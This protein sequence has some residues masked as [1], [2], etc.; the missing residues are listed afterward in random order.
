[1][2]YLFAF[3][4]TCLK[5]TLV[6]VDKA[7][8]IW[9]VIC[10]CNVSFAFYYCCYRHTFSH[11]VCSFSIQLHTCSN[12]KVKAPHLYF[13]VYEGMSADGPSVSPL[14]LSPDIHS[15]CPCSLPISSLC[16]SLDDSHLVAKC[17]SHR[18]SQSWHKDPP[19]ASVSHQVLVCCSETM[20]PC[21]EKIM[22]TW[23]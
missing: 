22:F 10:M 2:F 13:T 16:S 1:M 23:F 20:P 21:G 8:V 9:N 3:S 11:P 5:N 7:T 12:S 14:C 19:A 15:I 6:H 4:Q 17:I 18:E